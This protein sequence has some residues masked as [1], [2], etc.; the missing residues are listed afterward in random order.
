MA[1]KVRDLVTKAGNLSSIPR[2]HMVLKE[3][4]YRFLQVIH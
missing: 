4:A 1:Q 2:P 3:T